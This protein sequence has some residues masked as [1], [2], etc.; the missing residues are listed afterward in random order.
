MNAHFIAHK[1][2]SGNLLRILLSTLGVLFGCV[3]PLA[4]QTF[5]VSSGNDILSVGPTGSVSTYAVFT[6]NAQAAGL[7]VDAKGNLFV[8]DSDYGVIREVT[9]NGT[10]SVVATLPA[11]S[12]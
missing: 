3:F 6:A 9:P 5:Y 2:L 11:S 7:A 8:G 10:L 12:A 4:A 1:R